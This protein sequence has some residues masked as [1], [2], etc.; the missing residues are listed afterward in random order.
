MPH[1][2]NNRYVNLES[3]D[4]LLLYVSSYAF[5]FTFQRLF[6]WFYSSLNGI[7]N[8]AFCRELVIRLFPTHGQW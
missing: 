8:L 4:S 7:I 1:P 3:Y 5:F 6:M 2:I